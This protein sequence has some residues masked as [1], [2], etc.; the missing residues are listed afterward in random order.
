MAYR[1]FQPPKP[2]TDPVEDRPRSFGRRTS[3]EPES[4]GLKDTVVKIA[5]VTTIAA[6]AAAIAYQFAF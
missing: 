6:G 2:K 5:T 3:L 4:G 1:V